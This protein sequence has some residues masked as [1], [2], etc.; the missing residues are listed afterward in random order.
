MR[1]LEGK[2]LGSE[3]GTAKG[4]EQPAKYDKARQGANAALASQPKSYNPAADVTEAPAKVRAAVPGGFPYD[5]WHLGWLQG[6]AGRLAGRRAGAGRLAW[7]DAGLCWARAQEKKDKKK[8]AEPVAEPEE[9]APAPKKKK[10]KAADG[11]AN[12]ANGAAVSGGAVLC[13]CA[14]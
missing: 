11:E 14:C 8:K 7:A 4:K 3:A 1:Q 13:C 2:L 10:A 12:G 6:A 9:E 5:F